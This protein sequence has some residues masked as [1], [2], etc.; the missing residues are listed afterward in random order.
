MRH[1]ERVRDLDIRNDVVKLTE[2]TKENFKG[3]SLSEEFLETISKNFG[4]FNAGFKREYTSDDMRGEISEVLL[5]SLENEHPFL[6]F[7]QSAFDGPE[8]LGVKSNRIYLENYATDGKLSNI[9]FEIL[10]DDL[11]DFN[12]KFRSRSPIQRPREDRQGMAIW[13]SLE[14]TLLNLDELK[15]KE[16]LKFFSMTAQATMKFT[17]DE[18]GDIVVDVEHENKE[19]EKFTKATELDIAEIFFDNNVII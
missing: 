4:P 2:L 16:E 6:E 17:K 13:D 1:I 10:I 3:T 8:G 18:Y 14:E 12:E 19:H 5:L 9:E 7:E 15:C 11:Q